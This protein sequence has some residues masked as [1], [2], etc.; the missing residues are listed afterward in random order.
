MNKLLILPFA[1]IIILLLP[2]EVYGSSPH[3]ETRC[4]V[5]HS[6]LFESVLHN[7]LPRDISTGTSA[8]VLPGD[9]VA[10]L[11]I[12]THEGPGCNWSKID[13]IESG[14]GFF[15]ESV[16]GASHDRIKEFVPYYV[17]HEHT[18]NDWIDTLNRF[19]T[20]NNYVNNDFQQNSTWITSETLPGVGITNTDRGGIGLPNET[21]NALYGFSSSH[22]GVNS[23]T[24]NS[25]KDSRTI[26]P[27]DSK[28]YP[29]IAAK[30][31]E[32][33]N[34]DIDYMSYVTGFINIHPLYYDS[35]R[36]GT[37]SQDGSGIFNYEYSWNK[38]TVRHHCHGENSCSIHHHRGTRTIE[39]D[40]DFSSRIMVENPKIT[41]DIMPYDI[42]DNDGFSYKNLDSTYYQRDVIALKHKINFEPI[43]YHSHVWLEL[44]RFYDSEKMKALGGIHCPY[45]CNYTVPSQHY[46][47]LEPANITLQRNEGISLYMLAEDPRMLDAKIKNPTGVVNDLSLRRTAEAEPGIKPFRYA[48]AAFN[49]AQCST[50][51]RN[52]DVLKKTCG[53][54][55]MT[56]TS[57]F[58]EQTHIDLDVVPYE[59]HVTSIGFTMYEDGHQLPI[60]NRL[61]VG[62]HY[63]G[64]SES[65][66]LYNDKYY[67]DKHA[68]L[69]KPIESV[70]MTGNFSGVEEVSKEHAEQYSLMPKNEYDFA[71][72]EPRGVFQHNTPEDRQ[73]YYNESLK[74]IHPDHKAESPPTSSDRYQQIKI[75]MLNA[76]I[77]EDRRAKINGA[78]H[79]VVALS[80]NLTT[81]SRVDPPVQDG[82]YTGYKNVD[83]G[84]PEH[85]SNTIFE[86][87]IKPLEEAISRDLLKEIIKNMTAACNS[88]GRKTC[89]MN[90]DEAFGLINATYYENPLTE[91]G[92]ISPYDNINKEI[93][94]EKA[95]SR[96]LGEKTT[97]FD[98]EEIVPLP[99]PEFFY[100]FNYTLGTHATSLAS[101]PYQDPPIPAYR[102][103]HVL[104]SSGM[105]Q[106][107]VPI[108]TIDT[109]LWGGSYNPLND[110]SFKNNHATAMFEK[111]GYGAILI[112]HHIA[113]YFASESQ[114][115]ESSPR[116]DGYYE[117]LNATAV[118]NG[119]NPLPPS[120][121]KTYNTTIR[122]YTSPES[123]FA[124]FTINPDPIITRNSKGWSDESFLL[125]EQYEHPEYP[126]FMP[127]T[128]E[129][130]DSEGETKP[131]NI[132][133][134]VTPRLHSENIVL[135]RT[136]ENADK[137][138]PETDEFKNL[139]ETEIVP[140]LDGFND[141]QKAKVKE[142]FLVNED[143]H[144]WY[145]DTDLENKLLGNYTAFEEDFETEPNESDRTEL[146]E[147]YLFD[148]SFFET[149]DRGLALMVSEALY[150]VKVDTTTDTGLLEEK[151][152]LLTVNTPAE[153]DS[154]VMNA[155]LDLWEYFDPPQS[156]FGPA[157][158]RRSGN[159]HCGGDSLPFDADDVITVVGIIVSP[160]NLLN[161]LPQDGHVVASGRNMEI[162]Q[163]SLKPLCDA[164]THVPRT[165]GAADRAMHP[166]LI[167]I[168]IWG[169]GDL[170]LIKEAAFENSK[171]E[172]TRDIIDGV[173]LKHEIFLPA[174]IGDDETK[175]TINT[176]LDNEIRAT[177]GGKIL[178]I[179]YDDGFGKIININGT[180]I[181]CPGDC[182]FPVNSA[183]GNITVINEWGGEAILNL[184]GPPVPT[185]V[186]KGAYINFTNDVV[187]FFILLLVPFLIISYFVVKRLE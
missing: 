24:N 100:R 148:R 44:D 23:V 72:L 110:T 139:Y 18:T 82:I 28:T 121:V 73:N 1:A 160:W 151:V 116:F 131:M 180:S 15:F 37:H 65:H 146:Y 13:K 55:Y 66:P 158:D 113:D 94:K 182:R 118:I 22:A 86:K 52:S 5:R 117:G 45:G 79:T 133:V 107:N 7:N 135:E 17:R 164:Q 27:E 163:E 93:I 159:D 187:W 57:R 150:D 149:N 114:T 109:I 174:P 6:I 108:D 64:S 155:F 47:F 145:N 40:R 130:V 98:R 77:Y 172:Y 58:T 95:E 99:G 101:I 152:Y 122:E 111:E 115:K 12:L 156:K 84:A 87:R 183:T 134:V 157:S 81:E 67:I 140:G 10:F 153:L 175:I 103:R 85:L 14:G 176:D 97:P 106:H 120:G 51:E 143:I 137:W 54:T 124:L 90:H 171:I 168:E 29:R 19:E 141:K 71:G 167:E 9:S 169:H 69:I 170:E 74:T 129:T 42:R 78:Y 46:R 112:N 30:I 43:N 25:P 92:R 179:P 136:A 102:E 16:S 80:A 2:P 177:H 36:I 104:D 59:P 144:H 89:G 21:V 128:V 63:Y 91:I 60:A 125:Y 49:V 61:G 11:I 132:R 123:I 126:T 75:E 4:S 142:A 181:T 62:L 3:P 41:I 161:G 35:M 68:T 48:A 88:D 56:D 178:T 50:N 83:A 185:P 34:S 38:D 165:A 32:I 138:T 127:I 154:D 70:R 147:D 53:R 76:I 184:T 166:V 186:D 26:T 39:R 31:D 96:E 20:S 8:N 33:S 105:N 173:K 119:S 162:S